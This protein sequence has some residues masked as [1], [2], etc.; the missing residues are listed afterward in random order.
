LYRYLLTRRENPL[1]KKQALVTISLK[2]LRMMITLGQEKRR[3]DPQ[4][5]LGDYRTAQL[6]QAA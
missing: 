1:R 6:Q 2:L 4:K 3:Y 5:V